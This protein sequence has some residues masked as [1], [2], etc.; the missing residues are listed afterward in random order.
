ML[1]AFVVHMNTEQCLQYVPFYNAVLFQTKAR[2][3]HVVRV[4]MAY[5]L[6]ST[7]CHIK[8]IKS[9]LTYQHTYA[10]HHAQDEHIGQTSIKTGRQHYL[11]FCCKFIQVS[12]CHKLSIY[13]VV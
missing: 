4:L 2:R 10:E 12:T 1:Y 13:N 9:Q 7:K 11:L 6:Y 3:K 5:T 8:L